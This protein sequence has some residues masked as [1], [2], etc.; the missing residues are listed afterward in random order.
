MDASGSWSRFRVWKSYIR[1][2]SMPCLRMTSPCA[3]GIWLVWCVAKGLQRKPNVQWRGCRLWICSRTT[4]ENIPAFLLRTC[5]FGI[6][7][8]Y[9]SL[10][11]FPGCSKEPWTLN[12][13]TVFFISVTL[14]TNEELHA[15]HS[16][17]LCFPPSLF[18][19]PS[20]WQN[21]WLTP[22]GAFNTAQCVKQWHWVRGKW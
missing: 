1:L 13:P 10:A 19:C 21:W 14:L 6:Y 11:V 16:G 5:Q 7:S 9:I 3:A 17:Y 8:P 2:S 12:P 4:G 22:K 18:L 20:E 15:V